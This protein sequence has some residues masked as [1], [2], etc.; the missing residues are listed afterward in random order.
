ML[1]NYIKIAFRNLRKNKLYSAINIFGLATSMSVCL[2]ILLFIFDQRSFDQFHAQKENLYRIVTHYNSSSENN[3]SWYATSPVALNNVLEQNYSGIK[4]ATNIL[5]SFGGET[6]YTDDVIL[7]VNGFYAESAFLN[8]FD[9]N[10]SKGDK[11]TALVNPGS[12]ILTQNTAEKFFGNEEPI[13]KTVTV[14]GDR[15]YKVTGVIQGNNRSHF[16][17]EAIAS[18]SSVSKLPSNA[19]WTS[20]IS[21]SYTYVLLKDGTSPSL[22]ESYLPS[23]IESDFREIDN[24]SI[25]SMSLQSINDINLGRVLNNEIGTVIPGVAIYFLIALVLIIILIASFNYI[26][27]TIANSIK[28][29]KEV[30]VRKVLGAK[31]GSVIKQFIAESVL[32]TLF[33][34]IG[35]Y[36]ILQF[37][38]PEFNNLQIIVQSSTEIQTSVESNPIILIVF[39]G[40]SLITGILAGFYPAVYLSKFNP[41]LVLKGISNVKGISSSLLRKIVIVSQFSFS[42]L[43]IITAILLFRQ[44]EFM[45]DTEY[46]FDSEYII[47]VALQDV[48]YDRFQETI[49]KNPAILE[50]AASSKIPALGSING[51][52]AQSKAKPER[53]RINSFEV[54]E[55]YISVM[56]FDLI[57]GRNFSPEYGS[58][59]Y[60][61]I[62][63]NK[64]ALA[65]LNL[66][67]P[68]EAVGT[69]VQIE[70]KAYQVIGVIDNFISSS[71]LQNND[72]AV[73]LNNPDNF[74]YAVLKTN[75]TGIEQALPFL[76]QSWYNLDSQYLLQYQIF[77]DQLKKSPIISVF[78]DFTKILAVITFFTIL[79]SCF[80]LLGMAMNSTENRKKEIALR[81]IL[82]ASIQKI[83]LLLTKDYLKLISI[84]IAIGG[85]GAFFL[86]NLWIKNLSNSIEMDGSV[87]ILGIAATIFLALL[88]VCSQTVFAS[89][90]NPIKS[91]GDE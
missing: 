18:L 21:N 63:L 20:N 36:L 49:S 41:A 31:R 6:K 84:A 53:I 82:G 77:D 38:I 81:K 10:L 5:N 1:K 7:Q 47:N 11:S 64:N 8:M 61:S 60:S 42:V 55:H 43:F 85:I 19:N 89:F 69:S 83:T 39:L 66:G 27:L 45:A 9:F 22:I 52:W 70:E 48:P 87:F 88:I 28:R 51:M 62:I 75:S 30:G 23:I 40:F 74:Y 24:A 59:I 50:I 65:A 58:D 86:N 57:A 34:L 3:G 79:I 90:L 44:F 14:L 15:E 56:G 12:V 91:I 13:G 4:Q 32:T 33:A 54:D 68:E 78:S 2:L 29:G 76:K 46:G 71:P 37:I 35:A 73:L 67:S 26:T 25:S 80:G 72:P 16:K 17:F